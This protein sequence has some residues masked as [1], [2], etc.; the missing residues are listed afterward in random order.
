MSYRGKDIKIFSC[1]SNPAL[2][3]SIAD[4][5]GLK[6]GACK[7]EKFK[8]GEVSVS[9][10]E[11]VRGFDCFIIQSTCN[12]VNDNLMELLVMADALKRASA[13]RITAVIPYFGY[14]RQDRK[15]KSRAPISAK[16][17]ADMITAAGINRV[18][19]MDLHAQQIQGFF[20]IPV[21]H[22]VGAPVYANYFLPKIIDHK[23]DYVCLSPD[24]GS[25][26]RVREFAHKMLDCP[27]AI[28]DKRRPAPNVCEVMNLIGSVEGKKVLLIDDMI[29]T[30]GSL[31]NAAR[32]A[33]DHGAISVCA[34]A[35]HAV[36]SDPAC[37]NLAKAPIKEV[38]LLDT[39]PV[40]AEKM[41]DKFKV[42]STG[43]YFANAIRC[44]HYDEPMSP[45][46][47]DMY[48]SVPKVVKD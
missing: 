14:A 31:C 13:T 21:D 4:S 25:V 10:N 47:N 20:N 46:I 5:L 2:A 22:L 33:M 9:I 42:L 39:I 48:D 23:G 38:I 35:T 18:M 45:M 27:I 26:G 24:F 7:V 15:D 37:E 6:L 3:Q 16:L 29:D 28:I 19:T 41:I 17:V 43:E 30:A 12:P 44:V 32:A 8:D 34:A 40:P 36:L 1:N 11:S